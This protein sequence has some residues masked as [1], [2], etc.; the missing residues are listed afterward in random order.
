MS[1]RR[2]AEMLINHFDVQH[3][4]F[5]ILRF[6]TPAA[7]ICTKTYLVLIRRLIRQ[8]QNIEQQNKEFRIMKFWD[9]A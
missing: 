1:N 9:R 2:T 6:K 8:K 5:D 7:K 3:S 4:L